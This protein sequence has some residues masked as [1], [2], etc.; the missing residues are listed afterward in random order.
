MCSSPDAPKPVAPLPAQAPP[1]LPIL[2]GA[3]G[4]KTKNALL[5]NKGRSSLRIDRTQPDTGLTGSG[6]SIPT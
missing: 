1:L 6:L 5:A 2:E 4:D 3:Y